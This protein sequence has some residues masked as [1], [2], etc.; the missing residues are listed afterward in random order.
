VSSRGCK[1]ED[2]LWLCSI[3]T[4]KQARQSSVRVEEYL[5]PTQ[6][7]K[8]NWCDRLAIVSHIKGSIAVL[9]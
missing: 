4:I 6:T 3:E 7:R 9:Q 5:L 2:C 8:Q 1:S